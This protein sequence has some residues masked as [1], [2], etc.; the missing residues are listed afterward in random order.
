[1]L[2]SQPLGGETENSTASTTPHR[3]SL[4]LQYIRTAGRQTETVKV[5]VNP[6]ITLKELKI[7]IG[8]RL[9]LLT[10]E[11]WLFTQNQKIGLPDEVHIHNVFLSQG[12]IVEVYERPNDR[13]YDQK[14]LT[15][16]GPATNYWSSSRH[17]YRI[18]FPSPS[19]NQET[20]AAIKHP[21]TIGGGGNTAGSSKT[22]N[23]QHQIVNQMLRGSVDHEQVNLRDDV[24]TND[25]RARPRP[26]KC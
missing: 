17:N 3:L 7:I 21:S 5:C 2:S 1:M 16:V 19:R 13:S 25:M 4:T 8:K 23:Q 26:H 6:E 12:C 24:P 18:R 11:M 22:V 10:G 15:Q 9:G 14:N 20:R